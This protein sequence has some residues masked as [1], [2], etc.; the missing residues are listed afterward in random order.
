MSQYAGEHW[1]WVKRE[2][3][4]IA[5]WQCEW[6]GCMNIWEDGHHV[7]YERYG[8]EWV[9]DI[10]LLCRDCH[11]KA[12]AKQ[13]LGQL[14]FYLDEFPPEVVDLDHARIVREQS[15]E[16]AVQA[17]ADQLLA[18]LNEVSHR[19]VAELDADQLKHHATERVRE[20]LS[21]ISHELSDRFPDMPWEDCL[22]VVAR[23]ILRDPA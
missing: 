23:K 13:T 9:E 8:R 16:V 18:R 10:R 6:P 5:G 2:R 14:T 4:K 22:D 17:A 11:D 19:T 20:M 3:E 21:A 12:H 15:E 7:T 1:R